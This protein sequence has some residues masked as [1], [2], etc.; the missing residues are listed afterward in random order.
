MEAG[1][2]EEKLWVSGTGLG[3]RVTVDGKTQHG[4]YFQSTYDLVYSNLVSND[5]GNASNM[6]W[7]KIMMWVAV[8]FDRYVF[9][10]KQ[11]P[12]NF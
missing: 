12:S 11:V 4:F 1:Q 8:D 9:N 2:T 3:T 6:S 10:I 5:D 7:L